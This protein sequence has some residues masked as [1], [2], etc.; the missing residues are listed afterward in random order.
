MRSFS[1]RQIDALLMHVQLLGLQPDAD[2][3]NYN[4]EVLREFR[5]TRFQESIEG[6]PKYY[7]K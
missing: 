7:C 4:L 5:A 3:A 1:G 6:N 2:T